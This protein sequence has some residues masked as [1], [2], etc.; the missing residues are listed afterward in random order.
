MRVSGAEPRG[1]Q[2]ARGNRE[3]GILAIWALLEVKEAVDGGAIPQPIKDIFGGESA[4]SARHHRQQRNHQEFSLWRDGQAPPSLE[5]GI[6]GAY[7]PNIQLGRKLRKT[8]SV[9]LQSCGAS[10]I[11]TTALSGKHGSCN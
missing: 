10:S 1:E 3:A 9:V 11:G 7:V 5:S 8:A 2:A 4:Q 6:H